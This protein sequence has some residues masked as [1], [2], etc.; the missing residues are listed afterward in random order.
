MM[1]E[2]EK[3]LQQQV[4]DEQMT[5]AQADDLLAQ[6]RTFEA[7]RQSIE[8]QYKYKCVGYVNGQMLV[9]D[10]HTALLDQAKHEH[11]GKLTYFETVGTVLFEEF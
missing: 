8:A 4:A 1:D 9:A 7:N 10:D 2:F 11:P 5:Q 6:R 3:M